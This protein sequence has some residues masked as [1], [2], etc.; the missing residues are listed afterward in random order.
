MNAGTPPEI[1]YQPARIQAA[2]TELTS[3]L[4][5]VSSG[6]TRARAQRTLY[7][8]RDLSQDV[9]LRAD[10]SFALASMERPF[11]GTHVAAAAAEIVSEDRP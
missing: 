11:G 1:V 5:G 2:V 8:R 3:L 7:S 6:P 4:P 9:S 10:C